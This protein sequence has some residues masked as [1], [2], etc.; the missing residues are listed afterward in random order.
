MA[1]NDT[2]RAA[3]GQP[4]WKDREG[5]AWLDSKERTAERKNYERKQMDDAKVRD[6]RTCR[7][8]H[9][10]YMP[11]KPRIEAAHKKDEHR[12]IGGNPAL[13]R[14]ERKKL[15]TFC[16]IHHREY[17]HGRI[18]VDPQTDRLFDG[19]CDFERDGVFVGSEKVIGVSVTRD[20]R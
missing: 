4:L 12:G 8:P 16:F 14:T 2:Q 13:D 11:K 19:P 7:F 1:T 15:I 5:S 10:E 17:D 9:C 20:G 18:K 3:E 6:A